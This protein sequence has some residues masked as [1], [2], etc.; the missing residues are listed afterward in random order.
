MMSHWQGWLYVAAV[1]IPLASFTVQALLGRWLKRLNAWIAT[2]AI[3]T[4]CALSLVGLAAALPGL[5]S[6]PPHHA[7][8]DAEATV[9]E[10]AEAAE[11]EATGHGGFA[12][13]GQ[14]N[15][16]L[17]GRGMTVRPE[18][19]PEPTNLTP[20][21]AIPLGIHIDGLAVIMFAMV[22]FIATL[23][24]VYSMGYMADDPRY[25]R[26]FTYLSLFC[27]S[28]LAL[29]AS[30]NI[31]M[32][33]MSW[34]LVGVC[35]YLLIG[36]WYEEKKNADAANKAFIVNRVGDVGML[37]GL[38][39]IW[40]Y[41]GT[42]SIAEINAGLSDGGL[43][44]EVGLHRMTEATAGKDVAIHLPTD[45]PEEAGAPAR[46]VTIPYGLLVLAGL[47]IFAGC[48]GKSAQFPIH[49]WL[50][51]AMAGP[52]PVSALIHAATMVAAGVYLVGRFFPLF[53]HEV[54]LTIGYTGGITL[55]IAATIA[56]VQT[57]YKKVL[58][59]STV[60][61][62]GFMMLA[63]GVGGWAAGLFH[64]LTH[65][66]FKA[67]LFLCAGSVYHSVHTY[68]MPV[69]GGL[70]KKMPTTGLC[71]LA[72]TLAISGVPLF[73]GFYSKDAILASSLY[74]T[75]VMPQHV[76][77]FILPAVGAIITAFY[78]FRMWFLIFDGEPRGYPA[79]HAAAVEVQHG[80]FE[81]PDD[82]HGHNHAH[83]RGHGHA[84]APAASHGHG[85]HHHANPVE[86][87]H[88]S[89]PIMT[90][91]LRILAVLAVCVGWPI[92]LL[93]ITT[94]ILEGMLETAEPLEA[95][96]VSGSKWLAMGAS[97][98]IA[99]SGIA[100]AVGYYSRWKLKNP[101]LKVLHPEGA[102]QAFGWAYRLFVHKWYFD[103]IYDALF[104][105]PTLALARGV[106]E[107]DRRVVDGL[108]NAS[109]GTMRGLSRFGGIFDNLAVDGLVNLSARV[110]YLLG[111]WGRGLQTGRLRGY[112][113]VLAVAVVLL[114]LGVF[115]WVQPPVR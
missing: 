65:A 25:P 80:H 9:G 100:A 32:V 90:W 43:R 44:D 46:T 114:F 31:F 110:A 71:M 67:L 61:Q 66:F 24:H 29:V 7:A 77:L 52:T 11:V 97:L 27:F 57:D 5:L 96:D 2:A 49:V 23:I 107:F 54:L 26:F 99:A 78:M 91:P 74:F 14:M 4:S 55:L 89:P 41:F 18:T 59:Y 30:A 56:M 15:W 58:A 109:A 35:S 102:A 17:I 79:G 64:L 87:A 45:A 95:M 86:H 19:V 62:L 84:P 48:V 68:E 101:R 33:F 50:P 20:A 105:R 16:V 73:S 53:T 10:H 98:L 70:W 36:F 13:T 28:M 38:G 81:A 82:A 108:V 8:E 112:L 21:L 6:G 93:P 22:T 51:D 42:F 106:A 83:D 3:G 39:L 69:L 92:T 12:W 85:H 40:T 47:G 1:L 103:E 63:L 113:G 37:I 34:E 94:P 60:S 104:V 76:L 88:E 111:D 72:G 75:R 115:F